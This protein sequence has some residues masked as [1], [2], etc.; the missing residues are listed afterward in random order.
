MCMCGE[1]VNVYFTLLYQLY[2]NYGFD[3]VI[4]GFDQL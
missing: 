1:L 2:L 4:S 3:C